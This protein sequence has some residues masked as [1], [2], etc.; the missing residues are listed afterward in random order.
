MWRH[1]LLK[2]ILLAYIGWGSVE[3][4]ISTAHFISRT[5]YSP[6]MIHGKPMC[7]Q[8]TKCASGAGR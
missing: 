7:P 5:A 8:G 4:G 1:P 6:R 2:V 3:T